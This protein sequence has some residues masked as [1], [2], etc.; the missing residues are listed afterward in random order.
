MAKSLAFLIKGTDVAMT[1]FPHPSFCLEGKHDAWSCGSPFETKR[2]QDWAWKASL[3]RTGMILGPWGHCPAE[4]AG[5][6]SQTSGLLSRGEPQDHL[7]WQALCSKQQTQPDPTHKPFLY[8]T[9]T[10]Q[11]STAVQQAGRVGRTMDGTLRQ[12]SLILRNFWN[13]W[14]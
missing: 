12:M 10:G 7:L 6:K 4:E 14:L 9:N 3:T 5:Q 13:Q 11:A 1:S 8:S 2:K